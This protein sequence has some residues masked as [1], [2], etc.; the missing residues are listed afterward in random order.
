VNVDPKTAADQLVAITP[1]R[2]MR[3][4]YRRQTASYA[5]ARR[6]TRPLRRAFG[7]WAG[8]FRPTHPSVKP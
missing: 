4:A 5:K 7:G 8:A 1:N 6:I 3:R 2:A